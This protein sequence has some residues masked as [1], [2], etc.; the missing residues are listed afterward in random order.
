VKKKMLCLTRALGI[1]SVTAAAGAMAGC[2]EGAADALPART[3]SPVPAVVAVETAAAVEREIATVIR[4]TGS[5]VPDESSEVTPFVSGSVI[6]TPVNVGDVVKVGQVIARL[7]PRSA[8]LDLR[9]AEAALQQAEA[10]AQNAK[11]EASRHEALVKS[12]DISRS[13]YEKLTTQLA[14]AEAAVAQARA[15]VA[16]A[17]KDV[18][19]TTIT[20]PLAG[21]VSARPVSVGEYVTTS[22]KVVTILRIEPIKLEL[23]V[24]ES[25]AGRLRRGME[26]R[27]TVPTYPDAVFR[28]VV[29]ALNV[30]LDPS[31][32]AMVIEVRFPNADGRLLPGMF[33]TAEIHLPATQ[34]AWYVPASAVAT[35]ANG[36]SSAVYVIE[37]STARVRVIQTGEAEN[38]MVRVL[39]GLDG[40]ALVATSA[41]DQL[42][43]GAAVRVSSP[44]SGHPAG[45]SR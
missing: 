35:I 1:L 28:G 14:T 41:L 11:V 27:A 22:S 32:R 7:D 10:Q 24:P 44:A 8:T 39:A 20:A 45:S 13:A 4:A 33:G 40:T 12:G 15:R 29:A 31:S 3:A 37:G 30:A 5:F 23:Q 6:E 16:S 17:R 36:Q 26:V 42:F 34:R 2:G 9:H 19:D 21:H 25:E 18:D 38:G 43:D